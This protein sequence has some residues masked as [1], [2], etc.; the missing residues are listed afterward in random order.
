MGITLLLKQLGTQNLRAG[1][2]LRGSP[3]FLQTGRLRSERATCVRSHS[4]GRAAGCKRGM[5]D[6]K[7]N[8]LNAPG[9]N[10]GPPLLPWT[11][12]GTQSILSHLRRRGQ[13][14]GQEGGRDPQHCASSVPCSLAPAT[15]PPRSPSPGPHSLSACIHMPPGLCL[16]Q[17]PPPGVL[18]LILDVQPHLNLKLPGQILIFRF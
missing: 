11:D 7:T 13:L 10:T 18:S 4:Q 1:K 2:L 17:S 14:P 9:K 5:W 15:P 6:S 12:G 3:P 8:V 16:G